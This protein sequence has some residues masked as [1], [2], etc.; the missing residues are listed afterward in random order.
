MFTNTHKLKLLYSNNYKI[1]SMY[2]NSQ[3][4]QKLSTA[5]KQ[6]KHKYVHP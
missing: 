4:V 5:T 6:N 1:I 2:T 3:Y